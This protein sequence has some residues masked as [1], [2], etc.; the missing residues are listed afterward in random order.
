LG[1]GLPDLSIRLADVRAR[2]AAASRRAGRNVEGVVL[3]GVVKH[4]PVEMIGE[5]VRLGL[6]DVAENRVQEAGAA[7][8]SVGR[9]SVRWHMVGHLQ[10][11]KVN[12]ALELFD[13]FHGIDGPEIAGL[14]STRA[15]A[16]G[17]RVPVLVQVNAA[18]ET[19]KSGVSADGLPALVEHVAGLPGLVLDGLMTI[20]PPVET[21]E[22]ARGAFAKLR[23]LRDDAQRRVGVRLPE[24]SMGMSGDFEVAIEEGSTMVRVGTALFGPR[25]AT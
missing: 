23:E 7:V 20:G 2:I 5:A 11:N 8:E 13:R 1:T 18:G 21:A 16:R 25:T 14:L 17:L 24:L 22:Q 10:R 3:V 15:V 9:G 19:T 12:R 6:R 4:V